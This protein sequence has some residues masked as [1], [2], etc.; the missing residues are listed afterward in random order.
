MMSAYSRVKSLDSA[1]QHLGRM[2]NC[3]DIFNRKARLSDHVRS[4]S[5]SKKADI[6]LDQTFGQVKQACF[7]ID[8]DDSCYTLAKEAWKGSLQYVLHTCLLAGRHFAVRL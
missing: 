4:A 6:V 7:V 5:G 2:G 3:R 8:R 1:S